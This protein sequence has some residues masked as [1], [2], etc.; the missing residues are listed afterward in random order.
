[1][2]VRPKI[3][4]LSLLVTSHN[5]I[6]DSE[7]LLLALRS[8]QKA[9]QVFELIFVND[10]STDKT[11]TKLHNLLKELSAIVIELPKRQGLAI[12]RNT[13]VRASRGMA[14]LFLDQRFAPDMNLLRIHASAHSSRQFA[15]IAV[16]G[17][18]T[19]LRTSLANFV[20][21]N[22]VNISLAEILSRGMVTAANRDGCLTGGN[23]SVSRKIFIE[24]GTWFDDTVST[25]QEQD[26]KWLLHVASLGVHFE[27]LNE[28]KVFAPN[29][30]YPANQDPLIPQ[31]QIGAS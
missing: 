4:E 14:L 31:S 30:E 13:A 11:S 25:I 8:H 26:Y 20:G 24:G 2:S 29:S 12:S 15:P 7:K 10:G 27:F 19:G 1:M 17:E 28:A 18:V 16:V 3:P 23:I 9:Q 6:D 5:A 21:S 22:P